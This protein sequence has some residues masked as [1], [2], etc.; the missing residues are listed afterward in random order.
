[1]RKRRKLNELNAGS[2]ADIA[3]LLLI[4]FLVV[5]TI[6]KDK[7]I[8][9]ILPEYYEGPPGDALG[10]NVLKIIIN[11]EDQLLIESELRKIEDVENAVIEFVQN[12]QIHID[13]PTSPEKAIISIE[14][15]EDTS[16]ELYVQVYAHIHCAYKKMRNEEA[17][18][19]FEKPLNQLTVAEKNIVL[20]K[21]PLK[22]SEADPYSL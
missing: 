20:N 17:M 13:K 1:M 14:N 9:V 7:G 16:Y 19:R 5:T 11:D 2:M 3:F 18:Y 8:P 12:P 22:L 6:V 4:F 21:Y 10:R 15:D